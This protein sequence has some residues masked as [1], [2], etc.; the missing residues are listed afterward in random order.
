MAQIKLNQY[1][2]EITKGSN[3][4]IQQIINHAFTTRKGSLDK[5]RILSLFQLKIDNPLWTEAM[6]LI[7]GSIETNK[8]KRYCSVSQRNDEGEYNQIQLNFSSL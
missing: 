2:H 7:K 4:E 5:A 1:V 8:T 3:S 6:E